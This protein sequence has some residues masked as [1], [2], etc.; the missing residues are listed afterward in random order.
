MLIFEGKPY[1][2]GGGGEV[3]GEPQLMALGIQGIVLVDCGFQRAHWKCFR[4]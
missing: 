3:G 4:I 1:P 2:G